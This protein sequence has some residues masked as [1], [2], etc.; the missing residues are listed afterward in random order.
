MSKSVSNKRINIMTSCD[1]NYA[2][3]IPV[4]LLSIADNLIKCNFD[5]PIGYEI[6]FYLFYSR[7]S[8][9]KISCIRSYCNTLGIEFHQVFI[10]D[11][12]PYAELASKGGKWTYEAYFSIECQR[13]LPAEV[14]RILYIDAAD[15]LIIGDI[16]EYYFTD[17]EDCSI[18][19]TC[20]QYKFDA[21]GGLT[22]IESDDLYNDE[23]FPRILRGIFNSGSYVINVNKM[24]NENQSL[25][26]YIA[27][28]KALENIYPD[29]EEIYF[30]DQG[31]LAAAN[32]GDIRYYAY[33]EIKNLWFQPYNFCIWFFDRAT[34]IC[35][36]NPWYIPRILH[37]AGGMKPWQLTSKNESELKPGQWPFYKIYKLYANQIPKSVLEQMNR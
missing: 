11:A 15:I 35:G 13:Y 4:Q 16:G 9:E 36:G 31:L 23:L 1:D 25:N 2:K 37:F 24:R 3:L 20:S 32:V 14:D 18:I 29:K 8:E 30:G 34:E 33:P 28:K 26:D 7:V 6:H 5:V 19:V 17:F 22:A 12:T 10:A 27:L 21:N